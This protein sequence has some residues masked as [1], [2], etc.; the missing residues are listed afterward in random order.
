MNIINI[1]EIQT[2]KKKIENDC[3]VAIPT[4]TIYGIGTNIKSFQKIIDV[5]KRNDK[6]LAILCSSIEQMQSIINI[7][8]IHIETLKQL[9]P[10]A[11]TIVGKT[12][13]S[14][15]NINKGFDTTGVRIPNHQSLLKLLKET[16]PLVVSSAN[17]SGNN[18][19]YYLEDVI[20]I[21][22]DKLDIYITNDQEMTKQASTVINIET[23]EVYRSGDNCSDIIAALK[24]DII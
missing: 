20:D 22:K 23:L 8:Y 21:F 2:I 19:T 13:D 15:F 4:D 3:I 17:I 6:P 12:I 1:N 11:L 24:S 10:G 7:P 5:K 18:E 14:K 9:T 16:G